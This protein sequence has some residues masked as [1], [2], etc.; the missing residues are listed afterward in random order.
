MHGILRD[1]AARLLC[2]EAIMSARSAC[3][4]G[5]RWQ[6]QLDISA[7]STLAGGMRCAQDE[8]LGL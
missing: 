7:A 1:T 2:G 4:A 8:V 3:S 6:G 5:A